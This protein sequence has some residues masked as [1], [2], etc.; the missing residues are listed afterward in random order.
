MD[1]LLSMRVFL[2]VVDEGGF[3]SAARKMDLSPAA[4]TRLVADLEQYLD[5][6]LLQRTTRRL[7]LTEAGEEY[8]ARLRVLLADVDE[9]EAS[10]RGGTRKLRGSV[11]VLAPTAFATHVIVPALP[12]FLAKYPEIQVDLRSLDG[13]EPTLEDHDLTFVGSLASLPSDAVTRQLTVGD[14]ALYASPG[15]LKKSGVPK[16]PDDLAGHRILKH[17]HFGTPMDEIHLFNPEE[18]DLEL[19]VRVSPSLVADSTE[20]LLRATLEGVGISSQIQALAARHVS[21][22]LLRR[23]LAPWIT[24]R[25]SLMIAYPN[26]R[27][28][29][30]RAR[31]FLD[32]IVQ[33]GQESLADADLANTGRRR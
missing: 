33:T 21:S 1:R 9:T 20:P 19:S 31:A 29:S 11:R 30:A 32:H 28:L 3:A 25:L 8:T 26:R 17:R 14:T 18:G 10:V 13:G 4:V 15:Y 6:T 27:F 16:S 5:V 7:S 22:G 2:R 24:R 12:S 23:V